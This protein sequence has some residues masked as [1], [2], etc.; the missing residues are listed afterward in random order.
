MI[1]L[2]PPE[3]KEKLFWE[4]KLRIAFILGFLSIVCLLV[5]WLSL[6]ILK[7]NINIQKEVTKTAFQSET[8]KIEQINTIKREIAKINKTLKE[9]NQI[10]QER[11]L[12]SEVFEKLTAW[13]PSDAYL[14][15]LSLIHI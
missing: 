4:K 12:L 5:L 8:S 2:L 1:N 14:D 6:L 11:I 13:L 3:E 9:I 15:N 10:S 7:I